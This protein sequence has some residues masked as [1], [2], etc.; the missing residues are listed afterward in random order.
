MESVGIG[1]APSNNSKGSSFRIGTE[2]EG[3]G[4]Y[5]VDSNKERFLI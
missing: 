2:V 3:F 5:L 1:C 4:S